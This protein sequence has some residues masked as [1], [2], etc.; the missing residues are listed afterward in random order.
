MLITMK[1]HLQKLGNRMTG[2]EN[3]YSFL[4]THSTSA[5]WWFT[6]SGLYWMPRAAMKKSMQCHLCFQRHIVINSPKLFWEMQVWVISSASERGDGIRKQSEEMNLYVQPGQVDSVIIEPQ[7]IWE[8][9]KEIYL[10]EKWHTDWKWEWRK[11]LG[12][13]LREQGG[14]VVS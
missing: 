7:L 9:W 12:F 6:L 2:Q 4:V 13:W 10:R 5:S 8:K 11:L 1:N 14:Y 3:I